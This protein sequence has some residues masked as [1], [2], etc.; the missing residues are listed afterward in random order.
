MTTARL[1]E[2]GEATG[3]DFCLRL[4]TT[5]VAVYACHVQ[6]KSSQARWKKSLAVSLPVWVVWLLHYVY[7]Y[8]CQTV[9]HVFLNLIAS[10]FLIL[11]LRGQNIAPKCLLVSQQYDALNKYPKFYYNQRLV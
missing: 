7:I 6:S 4:Y 5:R 10:K 8:I 3:Q 2:A 1:S 9:K 11:T